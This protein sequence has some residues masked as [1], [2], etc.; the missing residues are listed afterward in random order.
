MVAVKTPPQPDY[1]T[2]IR[3]GAKVD[4]AG[5]Q[6]PPGRH[7]GHNVRY[8]LAVSLTGV[9]VLFALIYFLFFST[10]AASCT[11]MSS[12]RSSDGAEWVIQPDEMKSTPVSAI[13]A[14]VSG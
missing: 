5:A 9:V 3:D 6:C 10:P 7:P 1:G 12:P 8:V 13:A 4:R 14:T 11:S 2:E